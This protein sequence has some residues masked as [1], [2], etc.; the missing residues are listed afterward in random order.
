VRKHTHNCTHKKMRKRVKPENQSDHQAGPMSGHSRTTLRELFAQ[1]LQN[2]SPTEFSVPPDVL[3]VQTPGAHED[4]ELPQDYLA[5]FAGYTP[6]RV[7]KR[8]QYRPPLA[9]SVCDMDDV[10]QCTCSVEDGCDA[11]CQNRLLY[12]LVACLCIIMLC[13]WCYY[14]RYI[15]FVG[16]AADVIVRR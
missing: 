8:N 4:Y 14:H 12:M 9:R 2:V 1:S 3:R 15:A 16:S 7:L 5:E 13:I 11:D 6:F 10:P